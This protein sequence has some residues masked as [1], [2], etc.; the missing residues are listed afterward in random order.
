MTGLPFASG[1]TPGPKL[2]VGYHLSQLE[3]SHGPRQSCQFRFHTLDWRAKDG[4]LNGS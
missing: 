3:G 4:K 2:E 1:I